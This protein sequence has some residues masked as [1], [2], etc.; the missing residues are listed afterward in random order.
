MGLEQGLYTTNRIENIWSRIKGTQLFE[1]GFNTTN[2]NDVVV[3]LKT[4]EYKVVYGNYNGIIE[5]ISRH[6]YVINN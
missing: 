2:E 5:E 6:Q 4:S 3:Q 1:S